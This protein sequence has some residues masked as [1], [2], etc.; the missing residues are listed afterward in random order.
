MPRARTSDGSGLPFS[1]ARPGAAVASAANATK[2]PPQRNTWFTVSLLEHRRAFS[3]PTAPAPVRGRDGG[4]GRCCDLIGTPA[5]GKRFSWPCVDSADSD[6]GG[7]ARGSPQTQGGGRG[8]QIQPV[9]TQ[10]PD[11]GGR[12]RR[13]RTAARQQD[14]ARPVSHDHPG[15]TSRPALL[16]RRLSALHRPGASGNP[17]ARRE[18]AHRRRAGGHHHRQGAR[19]PVQP[20]QPPSGAG[21]LRP[22]PGVAR[23]PPGSVDR[24]GPADAAQP[25]SHAVRHRSRPCR[26]RSERRASSTHDQRRPQGAF[27]RV[28]PGKRP[29]RRNRISGRPPISSL[30]WSSGPDPA[31]WKTV[32]CRSCIAPLPA[33]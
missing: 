3:A 18:Y 8:G 17:I 4:R 5:K 19:L 20:G 24:L 12:R 25:G 21:G 23:S 13:R 26:G 16:G 31:P 9:G 32:R 28:P 15:Q 27:P 14:R 1:G 33:D 10:R 11:P 2:A 7:S 29:C 22:R 6:N 30:T